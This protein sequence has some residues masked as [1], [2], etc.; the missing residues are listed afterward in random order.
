MIAGRLIELAHDNF[1]GQQFLFFFGRLLQF[2]ER[3]GILLQLKQCPSQPL[4]DG[5]ALGVERLPDG[6]MLERLRP[7][8]AVLG[9][10][11]QPGLAADRGGFL[12]IGVIAERLA[13]RPG[14]VQQ[15]LGVRDPLLVQRQLAEQQ[16]WL[17]S[18]R[19][20]QDRA[21]QLLP[22][23][24]QLVGRQIELRQKNA[25]GGKLR[26]LGLDLSQFFQRP[27]RVAR[28]EDLHRLVDALVRR[29]SL[30]GRRRL[31]GVDVGGG[32]LMAAGAQKQQHQNT[33]SGP[34]RDCCHIGHIERS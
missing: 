33:A 18:F 21:F 28:F 9:H 34:A 14:A 19:I 8:A 32:P 16:I 5:P 26:M 15:E 3:L 1:G 31:A 6:Q 12:A 7:L 25:R 11:G 27:F 13:D 2:D 24:R 30:D 29:V 23:G 20:L 17:R 22:G 10:G 4:M